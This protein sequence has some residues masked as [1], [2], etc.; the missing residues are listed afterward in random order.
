[1]SKA[2]GKGKMSPEELLTSEEKEML[3]CKVWGLQTQLAMGQQRVDASNAQYTALKQ[4]VLEL[5]NDL[6]REKKNTHSIC[7]DLKRQKKELEALHAEEI[8][9]LT[10]NIDQQKREIVAK[11]DEIASLIRSNE[12]QIL[13]KNNELKELRRK[14]DEMS[15]EFSKILKETLEKMQVRFE[16]TD[17]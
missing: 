16:I 6:N 3:A 8:E 10:A 2:K 11:E 14:M 4:K 15:S 17:Y 7:E 1:M 12:A 13:E 9:R 5:S